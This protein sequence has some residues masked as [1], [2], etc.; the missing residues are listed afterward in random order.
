MIVFRHVDARYPF[1]WDDARQPAGRWHADGDGPAHYFADT[2][3]GAWAE[4][5]RHEEITDPRDLSTIRRR[6]WAVDIGDAPPVR[7]DLPGETLTGGRDTYSVCQRAAAA[8]R[9]DG[10][11]RIVARSAALV[12]GGARAI[13]MANGEH[14]DE[15]R[16]GQTIVIFGAPD[17]LVGWIAADEGSPPADLLDRVHHYR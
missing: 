17:D 4:F 14:P 3:D 8:R 2:P 11:T 16:D 10:V 1:L 13:R 7:V 12:S 5:L 6:M 15:P 9:R